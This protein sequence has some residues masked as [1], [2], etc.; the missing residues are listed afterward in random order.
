VAVSTLTARAQNV[1]GAVLP[2]VVRFTCTLGVLTAPEAQPDGSYQARLSST[3]EGVA[4]CTAMAPGGK[5][6][7]TRVQITFG[8]AAMIPL[9]LEAEVAEI[10]PGETARL[11]A[12]LPAGLPADGGVLRIGVP[13]ALELVNGSGRLGAE[14]QAL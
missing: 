14:A 3:T 9:Q 4:E 5:A 13:E 10:L 8:T 1:S 12:V 6:F 7:A 11:A 2:G